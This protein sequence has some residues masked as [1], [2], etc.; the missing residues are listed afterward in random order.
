MY[1]Y[2]LGFV[3]IGFIRLILAIFSLFVGLISE[4][5]FFLLLFQFALMFFGG[6][7]LI[8]GSI[9]RTSSSCSAQQKQ[10]N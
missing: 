4:A 3:L 10:P 7:V 6:P 9:L 2:I 5:M 1:A 8:R